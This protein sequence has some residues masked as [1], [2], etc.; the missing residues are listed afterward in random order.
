MSRLSVL[1]ICCV[2][3]DCA[4][5]VCLDALI[6]CEFF[7][8]LDSYWFD[9][10]VESEDVRW[11]VLVF[12]IYQSLVVDTVRSSYPIFSFVAQEVD[13]NSFSSIWQ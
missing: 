6:I 8:S 13:I 11:I 12:E 9:V 5:L 4:T 1:A 7:I 10:L 2:I 3:I